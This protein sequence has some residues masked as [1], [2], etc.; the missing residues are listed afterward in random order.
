MQGVVQAV[1][2]AQ[3]LQRLLVQR[4]QIAL[5]DLDRISR[6]QVNDEERN[7]RDADQKRDREEQPTGGI[8]EQRSARRVP[9]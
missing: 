3:L 5:L 1:E 2:L 7:E 6:R 9:L 8:A 4:V